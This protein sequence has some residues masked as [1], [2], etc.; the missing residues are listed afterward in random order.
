MEQQQKKNSPEV[1]NC[2][3]ENIDYYIYAVLKSI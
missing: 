3:L 2:F 1:I